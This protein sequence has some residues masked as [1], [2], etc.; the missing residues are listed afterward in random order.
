MLRC[1]PNMN[2]R[3][4]IYPKRLDGGNQYARVKTDELVPIDDWPTGQLR[5]IY[6]RQKPSIP[7]DFYTPELRRFHIQRRT[8]DRSSVM[9]PIHI[10]GAPQTPGTR[11]INNSASPK[12]AASS[13]ACPY[14]EATNFQVVSGLDRNT[15][16]Y[17]R[18]AVVY[19]WP[20]IG[21]GCY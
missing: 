20:K 3:L 18:K 9:P 11:R 13:S 16:H 12:H 8:A 5:T 4:A 17:W 21:G 7:P 14:V 10:T 1:S 6:V 2:Q 15:M 19:S